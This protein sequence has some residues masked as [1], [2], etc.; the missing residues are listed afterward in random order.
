MSRLDATRQYHEA[1][2][3][4]RRNKNP[5]ERE[6]ERESD[7]E[8][9]INNPAFLINRVFLPLRKPASRIFQW[10]RCVFPVSRRT[11]SV[12]KTHVYQWRIAKSR[13]ATWRSAERHG[14]VQKHTADASRARLRTDRR[15][16]QHHRPT[17]TDGTRLL[18]WQQMS[19][20]RFL[21]RP[22][23]R[24]PL[25]SYLPPIKS[26]TQGT[27]NLAYLRAETAMRP[28]VEIY[29]RFSEYNDVG[30]QEDRWRRAVHTCACA[31]AGALIPAKLR[32][33]SRMKEEKNTRSN[34]SG[35]NK[36]LTILKLFLLTESF[37]RGIS[38]DFLIFSNIFYI[39]KYIEVNY[40]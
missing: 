36:S 27:N 21:C 11:K 37:D 35:R 7:S 1:T 20:R 23:T 10:E 30:S 15:Y 3:K 17:A 13:G 18:K 25:I 40:L 26:H 14:H 28:F 12:V 29:L 32:H 4:R 8:G 39:S 16:E 5:R 22:L 6:R 24:R 2:W 19:R 9:E 34:V 33:D 31:C 38:F